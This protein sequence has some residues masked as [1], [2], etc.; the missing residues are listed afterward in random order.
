MESK[1]FDEVIAHEDDEAKN[2]NK[3]SNMIRSLYILASNSRLHIMLSFNILAKY[4]AKP[5]NFLVA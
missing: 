1:L 4:S 2:V 3:Y 5:T